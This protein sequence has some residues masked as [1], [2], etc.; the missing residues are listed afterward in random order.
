MDLLQYDVPSK[1]CLS[2]MVSTEGELCLTRCEG[3]SAQQWS[4][5]QA[6][7]CFWQ[8][9]TFLEFDWAGFMTSRAF[10]LSLCLPGVCLCVISVLLAASRHILAANCSDGPEPCNSAHWLMI[11]RQRRSVKSERCVFILVLRA[12]SVQDCMVVDESRNNCI[13]NAGL[14]FAHC[15]TL[16]WRFR[17]LV[18]IYGTPWQRSYSLI[19]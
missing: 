12:V 11:F 15:A 1:P 16:D 17:A 4:G 9:G 14:S 13:S 5:R 7:I 2:R 19:R 10:T 8:T 18:S 6:A 3:Y